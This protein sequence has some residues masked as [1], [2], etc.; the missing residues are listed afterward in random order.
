MQNLFNIK[1]NNINHHINRISGKLISVS[2]VKVFVKAQ[3][4][5]IITFSKLGI[6]GTSEKDFFAAAMLC[7]K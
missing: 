2:A 4:L 3:S 1:P 6:K 5:F 7:N